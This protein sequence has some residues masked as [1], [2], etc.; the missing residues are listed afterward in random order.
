[1]RKVESLTALFTP[2]RMPE[3][4]QKI[5]LSCPKGEHPYAGEFLI[6]VR[7]VNF[8]VVSW[9]YDK[10]NEQWYA[11]IEPAEVERSKDAAKPDRNAAGGTVLPGQKV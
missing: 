5:H 11:V 6:D 3:P 2:W 9:E 8:F 10:F 7:K 4:M 1:M